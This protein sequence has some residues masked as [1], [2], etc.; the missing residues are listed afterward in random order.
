MDKLIYTYVVSYDIQEGDEDKVRNA[1]REGLKEKF[2]AD[3]LSRSTYAFKSTEAVAE[4][5][6]V[7]LNLF[8]KACKDHKKDVTEKDEMWLVCTDK[9]ADFHTERPYELACYNLIEEYLK[10]NKLI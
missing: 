9:Q 5:R 8:S 7:I 10:K 6:N 1:F 4:I 2:N 3:E